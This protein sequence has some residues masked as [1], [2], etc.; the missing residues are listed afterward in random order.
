MEDKLQDLVVSTD[1]LTDIQYEL[2]KG[3]VRLEKKK[4]ELYFLDAFEELRPAQKI[5]VVLLAFRV[6]S[7]LGLPTMLDEGS[8]KGIVR[9]TGLPPGTVKP[10]LRS[11]HKD[12]LVDQDEDGKYFIPDHAMPRVRKQF[13]TQK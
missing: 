5:I 2:L 12:R 3:F 13:V 9:L 4:G 7:K 11:L 10:S 8:P 1:Y 6:K